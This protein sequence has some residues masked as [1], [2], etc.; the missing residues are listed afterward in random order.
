MWSP[1]HESI[2][3]LAWAAI[4][5]YPLG[6]LV[7]YGALLFA[8]RTA[9][10]K[11]KSTL[12]SEAT[13]FLH[14]E[15]ESD[16]FWWE[17]MEMARRVVLVGIMVLVWRGSITQ[18]VLAT[19]LNQIFLLL[20]MQSGP[21]RDTS[22]DYLANASSFSLVIVFLCCIIFKIGSLTELDVLKRRMAPEQR[23]AFDVP[24][25]YLL[26]VLVVSVIATLFLSFGLLLKQLAIEQA[27]IAREEKMAKARRLRDKATHG[28]VEVPPCKEDHYHTF[29]SHV[30]GYVTSVRTR[31]H[32]ICKRH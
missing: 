14:R 22:D 7:V 10:R 21:F 16:F 31:N 9:I 8:A 23:E 17:L 4:A 19:V 11:G 12:L 29:L 2:K 27:R 28:E 30:W 26:V 1:Q 18:L 32:R 5:I 3:A 20:Q 24:A 25:D 6:L 15:Y 13:R